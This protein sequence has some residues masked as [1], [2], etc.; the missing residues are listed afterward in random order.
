MT[1]EAVRSRIEQIGIIPAI[2]ALSLEDALFA[3]EAVSEGGIPIVEVT[4]TTPGALSL[5]RQLV[6]YRDLINQRTKEL[7]P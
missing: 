3:V 6:Q 4:M 1:R 7:E 2:R 5:I